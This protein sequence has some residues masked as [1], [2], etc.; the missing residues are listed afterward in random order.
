MGHSC[1]VLNNLGNETYFFKLI[2]MRGDLGVAAQLVLNNLGNETYFLIILMRG[3]LGM[4]HSWCS[5]I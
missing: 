1:M 2:L 3:G 4:G 5:I